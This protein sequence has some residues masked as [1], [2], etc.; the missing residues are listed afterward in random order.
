LQYY[1]S[2]YAPPCEGKGVDVKDSFSEELGH[3]FDQ[4]PRYSMKILVGDFNAKISRECKSITYIKH[5]LEGAADKFWGFDKKAERIRPT[6]YSM[7]SH[8]KQSPYE[9]MYYVQQL[10]HC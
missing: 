7:V 8:S 1:C 2:E 5:C 10:Y 3:V 6:G 4:F 9:I